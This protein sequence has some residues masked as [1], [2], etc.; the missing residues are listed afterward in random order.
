MFSAY[1]FFHS[2]LL[3]YS[4]NSI[5]PR[6]KIHYSFA[7]N[8]FIKITHKNISISPSKFTFPCKIK[9]YKISLVNISIFISIFTFSC[10][11]SV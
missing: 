2:P 8:I 5:F 4:P 9:F 7:F 3:L 1:F 6:F 11:F 10:L